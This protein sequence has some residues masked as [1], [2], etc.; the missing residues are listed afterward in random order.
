MCFK[1]ITDKQL[2]LLGDKVVSLCVRAPVFSVKSRFTAR[3]AGKWLRSVGRGTV[4]IGTI[5]EGQ[6]TVGD[7]VQILGYGTEVKTKVTDIE[8]SLSCF[9]SNLI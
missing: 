7:S 2:S 5:E 3:Q 8:V 4:A 6:L 9:L 1:G